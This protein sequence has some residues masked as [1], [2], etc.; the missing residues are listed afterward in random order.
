MKQR[1][2]VKK[3]YNKYYLP[4]KKE[5]ESERELVERID[6]KIIEDR[7]NYISNRDIFINEDFDVSKD[8]D[9]NKIY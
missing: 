9:W 1:W 2:K 3:V 6:K 5:K 4:Y 7:F 8:L